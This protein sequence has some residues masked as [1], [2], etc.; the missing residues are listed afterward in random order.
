MRCWRGVQEVT[1]AGAVKRDR[2]EEAERE[3]K[4]LKR[5]GV[6]R[7]AGEDDD[8]TFD[9]FYYE[10]EGKRRNMKRAPVRHVGKFAGIKRRLMGMETGTG[11]DTEGMETGTGMDTEEIMETGMAAEGRMTNREVEFLISLDKCLTL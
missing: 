11:M 4:I 9:P 1:N 6:K 3:S 8:E 10:P 5:G 2:E 7:I